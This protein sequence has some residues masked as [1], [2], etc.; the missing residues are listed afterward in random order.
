MKICPKPKL[1]TNN[2]VLLSGQVLWFAPLKPLHDHNF[3]GN[4]SF[5]IDFKIVLNE[6]GSNLYLI[7]QAIYSN[8]S[9]TRILLTRKNYKMLEKLTNSRM[10]Q[11]GSAI[12]KSNRGN[13]HHVSQCQCNQYFGNHELQIGIEST[14]AD[15]QWLFKYCSAIAN[16]HS[17]VN[18]HKSRGSGKKYVSYKCFKYNTAQDLPCPFP[19]NEEEAEFSINTIELRMNQEELP[20]P[21]KRIK[22]HKSSSMLSWPEDDLVN[23]LCSQIK[24]ASLSELPG[25]SDSES[26]ESEIGSVQIEVGN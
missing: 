24:S 18:V 12:K 11:E 16:S 26:D 5:V 2:F 3:Y 21:I 6:L 19:F 20:E 8:N 10:K 14:A 1:V 23:G 25:L 4:V 17:D 22:Y 7:D 13:Y 15:A 9:F